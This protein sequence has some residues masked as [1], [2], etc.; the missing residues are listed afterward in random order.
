MTITT[1]LFTFFSGKLVGQDEF[2]NRYFTEK[3]QPKNSK[4]K[5]WVLYNGRAEPS[6]VPALWHGWLHYNVAN[7][8]ANNDKKYAWEKP[9]QPNLTGTKNAYIAPNE[10]TGGQRAKNTSDYQAWTPKP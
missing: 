3:K 4:A 7:P 8:P 9:H 6:K 1:R 2:G 5:R 10:L